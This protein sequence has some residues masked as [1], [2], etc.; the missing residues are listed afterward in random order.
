MKKYFMQSK[1]YRA[2]KE[3][4]QNEL[5]EQEFSLVAKE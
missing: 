3:E 2:F 4:E 1:V 5:Q